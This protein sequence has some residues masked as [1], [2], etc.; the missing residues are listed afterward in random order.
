MESCN[1]FRST[2][3]RSIRRT[4][5]GDVDFFPERDGTL[6]VVQQST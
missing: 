4:T 6:V 1:C 5:F 2:S 3:S